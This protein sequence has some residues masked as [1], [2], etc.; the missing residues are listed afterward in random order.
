MRITACS[1]SCMYNNTGIRY[2]VPSLFFEFFFLLFTAKQPGNHRY[3]FHSYHTSGAVMHTRFVL[4]FHKFVKGS[5]RVL[6]APLY[7]AMHFVLW[8]YHLVAV[9][10]ISFCSLL[11]THKDRMVE[12]WKRQENM[13]T[14]IV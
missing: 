13:R 5:P 6:S 3:S 8:Y 1:S 11:K 9:H 12:R 2:F 14:F 7:Y 10:S 4:E